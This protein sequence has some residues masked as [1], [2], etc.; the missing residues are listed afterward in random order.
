MAQKQTDVLVIGSGLAGLWCALKA[1][2][3][4]SVTVVTKKERKESNT[5]YAQGGLAAVL[6]P[7]DKPDLHIQDTLGAGGGLCHPDIVDLVVSSG[8]P[9]V[10]ELLELGVNFTRNAGG[11]LEL[12]KEGGHSRRRIVHAADRTGAAIEKALIDAVATHP[13]IEVLEHH[14]C[15]DLILASRMSGGAAEDGEACWGAYIL[16]PDKEVYALGAKATVLAAGGAGKVYLY[17]SNPDVA[18]GDGI[19]MAFRAGARVSNMEFVQFHPTCLFHPEAKSFLITE[20]LRGEGAKLYTMDEERFMTRHDSRGELAPRD[21]VARAIDH[22]TKARGHDHVWLD[23]RHLGKEFLEKRFPQVTEGCRKFG[24]DP[25]TDRIPVVPAA[26]YICGGVRAN[27]EGATD[28]PRLYAIGEVAHSGLHGANRL[29]S[30]SLLEALVFADR[31]SKSIRALVKP[32]TVPEAD[33]WIFP[34][35]GYPREAGI[36]NHNWRSVRRL[37]WGYVGIERSNERLATAA[38]RLALIKQEVDRFYRRYAVDTDLLELRNLTLIAELILRLATERKESRGLNYNRD[39]EG[40][41]NVF[42][43]RDSILG[44]VGDVSWGT[45]IPD[46]TSTTEGT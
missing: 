35:S 13:N 25:V 20:A 2:E 16:D 45:T 46:L 17:T 32:G 40:P 15:V 38:P 19:A 44:R 37:M 39:Y 8:P 26:H 11:E 27:D 29:A 14:F 3:Y 22:E 21:I 43:K 4:G 30:N 36:L 9:L 24:I 23:A 6:G 41:D 34:S 31:A 10:R 18:T 42:Y 33:R 1:S 5:N 12:G 28:I 7:E